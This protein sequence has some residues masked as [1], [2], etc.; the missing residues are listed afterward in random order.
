MPLLKNAVLQPS[1]V[2]RSWSDISEQGDGIERLTYVPG[3]V[4]AITDWIVGSSIRPNRLMSLGVALTI[5]GT[6]IG[7]RI[8]GPTGSAT[9]KY[10]LILGQTGLGKGDPK[11]RG[12]ELVSSI[13][14]E[15]LIGP[16]EWGSG[17]GVLKHLIRHPLQICFMNEFGHEMQKVNQQNGNA[18]VAAITSVYKQAYDSWQTLVTAET[19]EVKSVRL[20][21]PAPSIIAFATPDQFWTGVKLAD[22]EGGFLNRWLVL[23]IEQTKRPTEQIVGEKA[24]RP[25]EWLKDALRSLPRQKKHNILD[26]KIGEE[27]PPLTH[28]GAQDIYLEASRAVDAI[29][30]EGNKRRWELAQ[31]I[32]E[33]GVR[34][35]TTVAVCRGCNVVEKQDISWALAL[36]KK[37]F[38]YVSKASQR[39]S[40]RL[41]FSGICNEILEVARC[42]GGD[43]QTERDIQRKVGRK[44]RYAGMVEDALKQ[45]VAEGRIVRGQT[46][47]SRYIRLVEEEEEGIVQRN[48]G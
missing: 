16:G 39:V 32:M 4:G 33:N 37:S 46:G 47:R 21:W 6:L 29:E 3:L 2:I 10:I 18:F 35:A 43:H 11:D 42:L 40:D 28:A 5:C 26:L 34:A 24:K 13:G 30:H 14:A 44:Q 9:H 20:H 38:E 7:R 23:P 45:L 25:P 41:D 15:D 48:G 19:R 12:I 8:K 31:R 36:T 1:G 22:I 17:V 27:P